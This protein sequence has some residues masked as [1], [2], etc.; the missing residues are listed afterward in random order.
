MEVETVSFEETQRKPLIP[1]KKDELNC[2]FYKKDACNPNKM[3]FKI[4]GRCHRSKAITM[5][6]LVPRIF[7]R[8]VGMAILVMGMT[9]GS[10]GQ[11]GT[12]TGS[13]SGSGASGGSGGSGGAGG[14]GH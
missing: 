4:C 10:A 12:S 7:E 3:N 11:G 2:I 13:G 5:E 14:G 1:H 6:N 9:F 8:I